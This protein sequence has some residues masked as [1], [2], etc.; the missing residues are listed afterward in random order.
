MTRNLF[1]LAYRKAKKEFAMSNYKSPITYILSLSVVGLFVNAF[2]IY[3]L[4]GVAAKQ[5][6][7]NITI[8]NF[9]SSVPSDTQSKSSFE[10]GYKKGIQKYE[11]AVEQAYED[12]YHKATEDIQC[13]AT[14]EVLPAKNNPEIKKPIVPNK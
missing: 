1:L 9:R 13:P 6:N 5:D 14:G 12:G 2:L 4:A 7:L 10:A 11:K 3:V 8:S